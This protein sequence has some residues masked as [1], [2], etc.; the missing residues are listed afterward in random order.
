MSTKAHQYTI[1]NIPLR[2]HR[3]LTKK[4]SDR[5]VSLNTLLVQTL[6]TEAGEG[7]EP[8][9]HDDLD[10]LFGSWVHDKAVDRALAEQRKVDPKDWA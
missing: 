7:G 6:E 1:R 10:D 2:V 3:A 8:R 4:A 5:G 9:V